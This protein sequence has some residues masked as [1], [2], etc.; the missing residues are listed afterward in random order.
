MDVGENN[1]DSTVI[2]GS[3]AT[4]MLGLAINNTTHRLEDAGP[5][6]LFHEVARSSFSNGP[7]ASVVT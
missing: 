1:E 2:I 4:A 5:M 6:D 3:Y 7:S